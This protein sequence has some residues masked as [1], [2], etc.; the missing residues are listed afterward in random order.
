VPHIDAP[1]G[2]PGLA[3]LVAYKRSTGDLLLAFVNELLR[4]P[5]PL[6]PADRELVAAFVSSRNDCQFCSNT[7]QAVASHLLGDDGVLA[8]A[9]VDDPA[10]APVSEK[11]R[12]LLHLAGKVQL[13][14]RSVG[15]GDVEAARA[16]GASDEEIHDTVLVA[17]AFCMLNRYVDGLAATTPTDAGTYAFIGALL[18]E[19]G[20]HG[21]LADGAT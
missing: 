10:A 7:H 8:C 16:V 9:V 5:S 2:V 3:S 4:G 18:A 11:L 17:A 14:G 12:A 15:E 20:Y 19:Q 1:A 21:Q 13:S 6:A